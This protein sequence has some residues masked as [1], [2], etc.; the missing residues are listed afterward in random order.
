[1]RA[2]TSYLATSGKLK[3]F[4]MFA[5]EIERAQLLYEGLSVGSKLHGSGTDNR[6]GTG[7]PQTSCTFSVTPP[8]EDA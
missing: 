1:M 2:V 4:A 7:V 5:C 6:Y 8:V 3:A